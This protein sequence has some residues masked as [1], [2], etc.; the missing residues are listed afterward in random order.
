MVVRKHTSLTWI[1]RV[2]SLGASGPNT[3]LDLRVPL[4]SREK[5]FPSFPDTIRNSKGGPF[6][7]VSLSLTDSFSSVTPAAWFSWKYEERERSWCAVEH[8]DT[9]T[10]ANMSRLLPV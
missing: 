2:N 8:K 5:K 1:S 4:W 3:R 7:E 6:L 9:Q 10:Q